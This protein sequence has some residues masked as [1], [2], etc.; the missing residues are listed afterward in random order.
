MLLLTCPCTVLNPVSPTVAP[1]CTRGPKYEEELP[2]PEPFTP[3][4]DIW[5]L[6]C[7]FSDMLVR[8]RFGEEGVTEYRQRRRRETHETPLKDSEWVSGFHDGVK[9]LSCVDEMHQRVL[10]GCPGDHFLHVVSRLTLEMLQ[11]R[12]K[13]EK[14]SAGRIRSRWLRE[15]GKLGGSLEQRV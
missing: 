9:R 6:G 5:A 11:P 2:A 12:E 7:V 3:W 1:E 4:A 10:E 14:Y 15:L 8:C 13:R